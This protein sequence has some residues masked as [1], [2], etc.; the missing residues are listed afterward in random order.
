MITE[1]SCHWFIFLWF[2][3]I[4][5]KCWNLQIRTKKIS[6]F[7]FAHVLWWLFLL[8]LFATL[9]PLLCLNCLFHINNHR[10]YVVYVLFV[11]PG[12]GW[13]VTSK[14]SAKKSPHFH[15]IQVWHLNILDIVYK[16]QISTD[17]QF[18]QQSLTGLILA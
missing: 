14:T 15:W 12:S 17:G 9:L 18:V 4:C 13:K 10:E 6:A 5:L 16:I 11:E 3:K 2:C 1:T 8:K 7:F